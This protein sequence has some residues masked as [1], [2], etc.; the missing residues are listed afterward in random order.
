M[1][2]HKSAYTGMYVDNHLEFICDYRTDIHTLLTQDSNKDKCPTG[3]KAFVIEDSS[4]W[5][6]NSEGIWKEIFTSGSGGS[7]GSSG[8]IGKD[9]IATDSEVG[10]ML[11]DVFSN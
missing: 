8:E 6:L 1:A 4:R 10:S 9:S 11:D 5:I 3:S 7:S 2:I